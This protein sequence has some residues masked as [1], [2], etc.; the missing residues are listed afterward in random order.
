MLPGAP[1]RPLCRSE[2]AFRGD[3]GAGSAIVAIDELLAARRRR[4]CVR[5]WRDYNGQAAVTCPAQ[6]AHPAIAVYRPVR[7]GELRLRRAAEIPALIERDRLNIADPRAAKVEP[8]P[9]ARVAGHDSD[10]V[11]AVELRDHLAAC[12]ID[13]VDPADLT[14][15]R[16]PGDRAGIQAVGIAI[17]DQA[18]HAERV[19]LGRLRCFC[20]PSG[21]SSRLVWGVGAT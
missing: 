4:E 8:F 7:D 14:I 13:T 10:G 17:G 11:D 15:A 6:P 16:A 12:Q 19:G 5:K 3:P 1:G 9:A 20:W 18:E 2:R 21:L